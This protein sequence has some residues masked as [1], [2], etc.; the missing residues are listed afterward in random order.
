MDK[1]FQANSNQIIDYAFDPEKS[2][3]LD[4]WLF[5]NCAGIISTGTGLDQIAAIYRKPHLFINAMPLA[6][7]HSWQNMIWVPK[8]LRWRKTTE[9]LSLNEY[10]EHNYQQL[11]DYH[12]NGIEIID[13]TSTE[14]L[15]AVQEFWLRL[16]GLD[17]YTRI[18]RDLQ[19][20][21]WGTLKSWSEFNSHHGVIHNKASVGKQWLANLSKVTAL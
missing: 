15:A 16:S 12:S 18:E 4:I 7:L 9:P 19:D 17:S 10:L 11:H 20:K 6:K 14:I 3:L 5:A 13:L 2:D 1:P 8:N 21:F